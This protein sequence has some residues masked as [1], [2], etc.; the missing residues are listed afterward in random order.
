MI[1]SVEDLARFASALLQNRLMT[2]ETLEMMW[3]PRLDEK[4]MQIRGDEPPEPLRWKQS[5][6]WRIRKD[7]VGRDFAYHCGVVKGFNFCLVIYVDEELIVATADNG[8]GLGFA[9]SGYG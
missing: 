4:V 2:A 5:L 9:V 7:E 8:G 1:S 6:L 3:Q